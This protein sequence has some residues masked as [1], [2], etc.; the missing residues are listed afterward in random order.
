MTFKS[1]PQ[2]KAA[3]VG[4]KDYKNLLKDRREKI[5]RI[6]RRIADLYLER[7]CFADEIAEIK[8]KNFLEITDKSVEEEKLAGLTVDLSKRDAGYLENLI[9]YIISESKRRQKEYI[10][11]MERMRNDKH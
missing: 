8:G 3:S 4:E 1:E 5:M 7:L 9:R 11:D 10:T 2:G 6:D